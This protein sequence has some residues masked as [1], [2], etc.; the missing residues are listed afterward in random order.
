MVTRRDKLRHSLRRRGALAPLSR[1]LRVANAQRPFPT[2]TGAEHRAG[3]GGSRQYA[4]ATTGSRLTFRYSIQIQILLRH[5]SR[6]A[7][8]WTERS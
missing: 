8:R 6:R 1:G 5:G 7:R 4:R 2:R 3:P